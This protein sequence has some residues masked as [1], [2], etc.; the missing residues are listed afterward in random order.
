MN[1]K[2]QLLLVEKNLDRRLEFKTCINFHSQ[3]ELS[4]ETALEQEGI[5][6]LE[7][8]NTD[9]VV[10]ELELDEGNGIHLIEKLRK[11]SIKQPF[12]V[13]T[14]NTCSE[15]ILQYLRKDLKVDFIF[16]KTNLSYTPNQVL[17]VIEKVYK[18]HNNSD[19]NLFR[20]K[21]KDILKKR[22]LQELQNIGF[23]TY[24]IGTEYI[25]AA[26]LLL[27]DSQNTSFQITKTIYP[28]LANQYQS[29]PSNVE[30]AIR[31]A[32][33]HVWNNAGLLQISKYYPYDVS[34]KNG[35]PSNS[36]FISNMKLKLF[37]KN[38]IIF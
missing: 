28:A 34:N 29:N 31:M 9:V 26:L 38:D 7:Q 23:S 6:F 17:C 25:I 21:E 1:S 4:G 5:K 37:G 3:F 16:Q 2:I 13:V 30:K 19:G 35:R 24:N 32:I 10:L 33:E 27:S 12:V 15:A 14:T 18:Y 36:E 22:I 8:G 11:L 20:L